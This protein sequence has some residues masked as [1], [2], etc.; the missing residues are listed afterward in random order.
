M[1]KKR[2]VTLAW[3]LQRWFSLLS[4]LIKNHPTIKEGKVVK[5]CLFS[6]ILSM[7]YGIKLVLRRN[8]KTGE[9]KAGFASEFPLKDW[10]HV[11]DRG[12]WPAACGPFLD[13]WHGA[14]EEAKQL[15]SVVQVQ[16][17]PEV[18]LYDA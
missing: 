6:Y 9:Y 3:H 11:S 12:T 8:K 2:W 13:A 18:Y 17:V 1:E 15:N 7:G 16:E 10:E 4:L 14:T 5:R